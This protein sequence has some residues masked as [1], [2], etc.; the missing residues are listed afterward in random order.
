VAQDGVSLSGVAGRYA[1]ALYELASEKSATDEVAAALAAF[2]SLMNDSPDLKRLVKSPVFTAQEQ[3]KALD[4]VLGKA[5]VSGIAANFIRLVASKRRL[6]VLPDM[7]AAYQG[8]HDKAKGLV[9]A[10]VTVA[11]P[12]R[13][14][15]EAALRQALAAVTGGKSV[16]LNVRTDPSVIGGIIVKLGSRMVDASVRTKL[17]S[18]RT[19]M[20]EVG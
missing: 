14:D 1:S 17:N 6:F 5:G 13:P 20:K 9:R 10:D 11:A 18:I 19:R 7:I 2:Q 4:A 12:L 16:S 3:V 8:L 15:H